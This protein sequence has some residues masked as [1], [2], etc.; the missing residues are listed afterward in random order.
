MLDDKQVEWVTK[1]IGMVP[2]ITAGADTQDR[3]Q[4]M[5][6]DAQKVIESKVGEISV[7][8]SFVVEIKK[9]GLEGFLQEKFN[10]NYTMS[11]M[12]KDA[13]PNKDYDS[14]HDKVK[15][16]DQ[17]ALK[18]LMEAHGIV[19]G[20]AKKLRDAF[21]DTSKRPLFSDKEI[22]DAI[23]APLMRRKIIPENAIPDRYS[24]VSRTFAGASGEYEERLA[25]YTES[26][27]SWD[28]YAEKLG[29]GKD[30][31]NGLG[32]AATSTV[33]SLASAG[34]N[35]P[36][37]EVT[38]ILKLVQTG[39]TGTIDIANTV[40]KQKGK[41]WDK[42]TALS[43]CKTAVGMVSATVTAG[44]SGGTP[45]DQA[46]GKAINAGL[47]C[48][49][50]GGS[51][52][53]KV[54]KKP[55]ADLEGAF[56]DLGDLVTQGLICSY[57]GFSSKGGKPEAGDDY[58]LQELGALIGGG[59]KALAKGGK[60]GTD[61]KKELAKDPV[62]QAAIAKL[63]A[64][65]LGGV[66]QE[67]MSA[68]SS[69]RLMVNKSDLEKETNDDAPDGV[70]TDANEGNGKALEQYNFDVNVTEQQ[71]ADY[72]K[73]GAGAPGFLAGDKAISLLQATN[74]PKALAKLYEKDPQLKKMGDLIKKQQAQ[75]AKD[76][77]ENLEKVIAQEAKNFRDLLNR[78]ETGDTEK[79][80]E[81]IET[82]IM[83][84]KKDQAIVALVEQLVKL[85]AQA[86]A[87]FLPQAGI[88]VT[89]VELIIN[90]KKAIEHFIA[91]DEWNDNQ[92]DAAAA[93]SVQVEAMANRAGISLEKGTEQV[94][95]ALE[96]GAKLVAQA[97]S[98]SGP[99]AAGG[100]AAT[101]AISA[102]QAIR[103]LIVKYYD[104]N[105]LRKAWKIYRQAL[106]KPEDRKLVREAIRKNPTLAKY[107]IAYGAEMD[108]NPVARN[109]MQKCGLTAEVLD[110][111]KT[112]VQ[113]VVTYLEALYPED[114]ILLKRVDVP[115][116]WF[117]GPIEFTS[118][119]VATFFAAAEKSAKLKVG[120]GRT[121]VNLMSEGERARADLEAARKTWLAE[122]QSLAKAGSDG[123]PKALDAL[124]KKEQKALWLV[125]DELELVKSVTSRILGNLD[126]LAPVGSDGKPH[127]A[128]AFYVGQLMPMAV[129][130]S[131]K[132][133]RDERALMGQAG[134]QQR[135][136]HGLLG[137]T[138]LP[139]GGD[140]AT[141]ASQTT[142]DATSG[143]S[144]DGTATGPQQAASSDSSG[145]PSGGSQPKPPSDVPFKKQGSDGLCA[146]YALHHFKK[147][148]I[149]IDAF[150]DK[151]EEFYADELAVEDDLSDFVKDGNDPGLLQA[152]GLSKKSLGSEEAYIVADIAKK[153][154]WTI[155]KSSDVW[156]RYDSLKG[157]PESIGSDEDVKSEVSG[158]D[159]YA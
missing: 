110:S 9:Q 129:M 102:E 91:F 71:W 6:D 125:Q 4:A 133:E 22:A 153:H 38:S 89:A 159:L 39:L 75:V 109:A 138:A 100:H 27:S 56:G 148:G 134:A 78:S 98:F 130:L 25:A 64:K 157:Q 2:T 36:V 72:Q 1:T 115:E 156:W 120:Q 118:A 45:N 35:M 113:K 97:M 105:E 99:L 144:A 108:E 13:D 155:R 42:E 124:R 26:L 81:A 49:F 95:A 54:T 51:F 83:Q 158:I 140:S 88:A 143:P 69:W 55:E 139:G 150:M 15:S 132:Y 70:K 8:E 28:K 37:A 53:V 24:E 58:N 135:D 141:T 48:G 131:G 152:F 17:K 126:S 146:Y 121:I 93:M 29:I 62:D 19:A 52:L 43:V 47:S 86:V 61:L 119:S 149:T 33:Q 136:K 74:D 20:E 128:M 50:F 80:M 123:D 59:I 76:A 67:T 94:V 137:G 104:M 32:T 107:V 82:L 21:D 65:G 63:L 147:G 30:V 31:I 60:V 11:S 92:N 14:G 114:P 18:Q 40:G 34:V 73:D 79:D 87:A 46:I 10:A 111:P 5:L 142:D 44:F 12:G 68:S 122:G 3:K 90:I 101:A 96:N 127:K 16:I 77:N 84:I 112:N 85:P 154:F 57:N 145:D 7:G 41:K 66:M 103:Q 23:W 151:A 116:K 106:E 117:P